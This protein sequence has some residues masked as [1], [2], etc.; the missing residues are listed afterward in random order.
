MSSIPA[1]A[2]FGIA[3]LLF[4]AWAQDVRGMVVGG[5]LIAVTSL[6]VARRNKSPEP[7]AD[8]PD[9]RL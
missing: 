6:A 5:V 3:I 2:W 9:E 8:G 7:D 1:G 4:G